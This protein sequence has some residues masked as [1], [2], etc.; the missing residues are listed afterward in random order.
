MIGYNDFEMLDFEGR[1]TKY[2]TYP[3]MQVLREIKNQRFALP[4][5]IVGIGESRPVLCCAVGRMIFLWNSLRNCVPKY[6]NLVIHSGGMDENWGWVSSYFPNRTISWRFHFG[7]DGTIN[8][9]PELPH[10]G[11]LDDL[12]PLLDQ[13][14]L[15]MLVVNQHHNVGCHYITICRGFST[16]PCIDCVWP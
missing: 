14:K 1:V 2:N 15:I 8:P 4:R 12:R 5:P 3:P 13:P 6:T 11:Q 9:A 10:T 16:L 7:H